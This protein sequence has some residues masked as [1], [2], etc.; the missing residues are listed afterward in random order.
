[1]PGAAAG[2]AISSHQLLKQA[3]LAAKEEAAGYED[4]EVPLL[5]VEDESSSGYDDPV[6]P[7]LSPHSCYNSHSSSEVVNRCAVCSNRRQ[8]G[9]MAWA[10]LLVWSVPLALAA[11]RWCGGPVD[12]RSN[13]QQ[14]DGRL[15]MVQVRMLALAAYPCHVFTGYMAAIEHE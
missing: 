7:F 8:R 6:V 15:L 9:R 3:L 13:L 12:P 5:A 10:L 4:P 14:P 11:A 2:T 1:M